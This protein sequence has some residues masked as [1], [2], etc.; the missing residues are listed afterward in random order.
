M[1]KNEITFEYPLNEHMRAC[2]RLEHLFSQ[3]NLNIS[4]PT[5]DASRSAIIALLEILNV[6]DRPDIKTKLTKS[7]SQISIH[8][9]T[10]ARLPQ[11][12]QEKLNLLL[13]EVDTIRDNLF[14]L[15]GKLGQELDS[16]E[17]LTSIRMHMNNP[18]GACDFSLPGFKL[19]LEKPF[20]QRF[21]DLQQ[22]CGGIALIENITQKILCIT[23]ECKQ[24]KPILAENGFYQQGLDP[25]INGELVRVK[26][27][28]DT[29]YYPEFSVGRP[30]MSIRF[31]MLNGDGRPK[32]A[33]ENIPFEMAYCYL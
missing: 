23:R 17:F 10:L 9:S 24:L 33:N 28:A 25:N 3:L 21:K 29:L 22:W 11:V 19:W 32:Q 14:K 20:E 1:K 2:L 5:A 31:N 12:D 26:L 8:F 6:V 4:Q 16:N 13:H 27:P 7:L 15:H 30:R 18:G